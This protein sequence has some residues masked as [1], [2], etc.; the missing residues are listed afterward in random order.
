M[1]ET[2]SSRGSVHESPTG[3]RPD[4][5]RLICFWS[6]LVFANDRHMPEC[7][8]TCLLTDDFNPIRVKKTPRD[9]LIGLPTMKTP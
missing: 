2:R 5:A 1:A 6:T 4:A 7:V 9:A 3:R 8:W